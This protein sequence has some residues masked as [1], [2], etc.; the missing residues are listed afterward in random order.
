L[1]LAEVAPPPRAQIHVLLVEKLL[2]VQPTPGVGLATLGL[3]VG[4]QAVSLGSADSIDGPCSGAAACEGAVPGPVVAE[5]T[6]SRP[7]LVGV[8]GSSE[9]VVTAGVVFVAGAGVGLTACTVAGADTIAAVGAG[10]SADVSTVVAALAASG[11][12]L[13]TEWVARVVTAVDVAV[14]G[15]AFAASGGAARGA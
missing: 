6:W 11:A 13:A 14:D 3:A 5:A 4:A 2:L 10:D 15:E 1:P 7:G 8:R 12:G 9:G